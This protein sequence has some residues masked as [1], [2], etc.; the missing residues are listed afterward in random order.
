MAKVLIVD[1]R[2]ALPASIGEDTSALSIAA[3]VARTAGLALEV[4]ANGPDA[5]AVYV[6]NRCC[7][8]TKK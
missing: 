5:V 3:T 2:R 6:A 1:E 8:V 4:E 7:T